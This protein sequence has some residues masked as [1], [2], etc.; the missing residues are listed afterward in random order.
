MKKYNLNSEIGLTAF[1]KTL[2]CNDCIFLKD[3]TCIQAKAHEHEADKIELAK[4]Y[5]KLYIDG[6]AKTQAVVPKSRVD[7]LNRFK[8]RSENINQYF[9]CTDYEN[10]SSALCK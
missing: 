7:M 2:N 6:L 8:N 9:V 1:L 10:K 3:K 4:A 5:E